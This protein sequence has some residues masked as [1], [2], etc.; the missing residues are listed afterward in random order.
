MTFTIRYNKTGKEIVVSNSAG[1][2]M[3]DSLKLDALGFKSR[4]IFDE[5]MEEEEKKI[6]RSIILK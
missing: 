5:E 3:M 1:Y 6:F 2:I 4:D